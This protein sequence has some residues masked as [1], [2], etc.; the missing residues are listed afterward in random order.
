MHQAAHQRQ[1]EV[2]AR[3]VY[4]G[5]AEPKHVGV[6]RADLNGVLESA[7]RRRLDEVGAAQ[8]GLG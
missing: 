3:E 2:V 1:D 7:G 8:A 5:A 6:P 4:V